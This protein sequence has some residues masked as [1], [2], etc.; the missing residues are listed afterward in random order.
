MRVTFFESKAITQ[1]KLPITAFNP[2]WFGCERAWFRI[3]KMI[4]RCNLITN[5]IFADRPASRLINYFFGC[6]GGAMMRQFAALAEG[7]RFGSLRNVTM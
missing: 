4:C 3:N 2:L 5:L 1:K 7:I 6:S